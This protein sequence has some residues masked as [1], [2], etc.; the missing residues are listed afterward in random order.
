MIRKPKLSPHQT[1]VLS[2]KQLHK[3][4]KTSGEPPT[5]PRH[6]RPDTACWTVTPNNDFYFFSFS[7][8][9]IWLIAG[10][11]PAAANTPVTRQKKNT[12]RVQSVVLFFLLSNMQFESLQLFYYNS[13]DRCE[14][15]NLLKAS[16]W[17]WCPFL[18]HLS[19]F[20]FFF[21]YMHDF[22]LWTTM[23]CKLS[24]RVCRSF[25]LLCCEAATFNHHLIN[26]RTWI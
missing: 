26:E 2:Q 9:S 3:P 5:A 18:L 20:F 8:G 16:L 25:S 23:I 7:G 22:F 1:P 15:E 19:L 11:R 14:S 6:R 13:D 24:P 12:T 4:L 17:F 21:F 10:R